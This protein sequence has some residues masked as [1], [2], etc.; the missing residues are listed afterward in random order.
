MML[1]I[2]YIHSFSSIGGGGDE[3]LFNLVKG[4]DKNKFYPIILATSNGPVI[5]K[6]HEMGVEVLQFDRPPSIKKNL[7]LFFLKYLQLARL[8]KKREIA[9]VHINHQGELIYTPILCKLLGISCI[10]HARSLLL[11]KEMSQR[12]QFLFNLVDQIVAVSE[13]VKEA[14]VKEE[15]K[16]EKIKVSYSSV[17]LEVFNPQVASG[18]FFRKKLDVGPKE[19]LV[20]I[21][22]RIVP[23][24]GYDE[25]LKAAT[26][27]LEALPEV[28]FAAIGDSADGNYL[29]HLKGFAQELRIFSKIIFT[30]SQINMPKVYAALDLVVL[31]SWEEPFARVVYEAMAMEKPVVGTNTGGTPEIIEH[32][33]N[34][35]LVP[36]KNPK[37]L[38]EGIIEVLKDR[39]KAQRMGKKGRRI[40]QERFSLEKHVA[41][42]ENIY[43]VLL[44]KGNANNV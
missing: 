10:C 3:S 25:F 14:L 39:E 20:G 11:T 41:E 43:K 27:V 28:K 6:L 44:K 12:R 31:A 2:L 23:W 9:I 30:G 35:L 38:A 13:A 26:I 22:G 16:E 24:K 8:I 18:K 29:E 21:V 15:V 5:E 32:G 33:V 1:N 36:P 4:L 17:N 19:Q 42:I 40:V 34:G 37:A 7:V